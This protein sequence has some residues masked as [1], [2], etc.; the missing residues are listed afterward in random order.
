MDW[1]CFVVVTDQQDRTRKGLRPKKIVT[2][3]Q[4]SRRE[5]T[6]SRAAATLPKLG[7]QPKQTS[8]NCCRTLDTFTY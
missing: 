6:G 2:E 8:N 5:V 1:G 4:D 3:F 7:F